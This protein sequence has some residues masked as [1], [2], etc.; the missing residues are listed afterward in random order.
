M[1]YSS[2]TNTT[3]TATT[4]SSTYTSPNLSMLLL[5]LIGGSNF[6]INDRDDFNINATTPPVIVGTISPLELMSLPLNA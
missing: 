6:T 1:S 5:G 2:E 4:S 3:N